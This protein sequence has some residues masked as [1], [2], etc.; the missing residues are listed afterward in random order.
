VG[1]DLRSRDGETAR[2]MGI[3]G[4]GFSGTM[5]AIHLIEMSSTLLQA[6]LEV[7]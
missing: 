2:Q 5:L 7:A 1:L 4:A 6:I 3:I